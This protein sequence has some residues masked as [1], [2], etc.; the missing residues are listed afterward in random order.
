MSL[1]WLPSEDVCRRTLAMQDERGYHVAVLWRAESFRQSDGAPMTM[2]R[3]EALNAVLERC[4]LP[5]IPGELLIGSGLGR[6]AH[7]GDA[8]Q[9]AEAQQ[10][11]GGI[12]SRDFWTHFDHYI[13]DYPTLLR[14]GLDGIIA[15][16]EAQMAAQDEQGKVFLAS[17]V[18]GLRGASRHI[19]RWA[20]AAE[21]QAAQSPEYAELLRAQA[22]MARRIAHQPPQGFWEALQLVHFM[23]SIFQLDERYAMALGRLDQYL[24]PFYQADCAAQRLTPELAENLMHHLIA[25]LAHRGDIQNICIGGVDAQ[26]NDATNELSFLILES[27]KRIGQPGGNLTARIHKQSPEPFLRKCAEVIRTGIGFPA[28][29]NDEVQIAGLVGQG[30]PLEDARDYAFVGCI[31]AFIP[32]KQAPWA[33]SRFN[34]LRCINLVLWDGWDTVTQAQVGPHTGETADWEAFYEA[35]RAQMEA[36]VA[37]HVRELNAIKQP[38]EDRAEELTSPLMSALTDACLERGRDLCDGGA[39]YPGNHGICGMGIGSVADTLLVI[40]RYVFEQGRFTLDALRTMLT[41]NFEGFEGERQLLLRAPKYGN[42]EQEVDELAVRAARDFGEACLRHTTPRGGRYWGLMAANTANIY[43][44]AEVGATADGRLALQPL[45]DAAS[46]TFGRDHNGPTAVAL[47]VA[48]LDYRLFPGGNVINMKFHPSALAGEAGLAGLSALVRTCFSM[49]GIQLQFNT[50][51]REVLRKAMEHPEEYANLVVR[52][53]GFSAY[54]TWL[55]RDV[56]ED[57]LARTEHRL[58]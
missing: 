22:A 58:V 28:L 12:G 2:R 17:V 7:A 47:S 33:D 44:G 57:I 11:L 13:P 41:A 19:E 9:L 54:F 46:P 53:S 14:A 21:E 15:R 4:D 32:G 27:V 39:R 26:G 23:H 37:E 56:Q 49:G 34:M 36:G 16:A 25:K 43:A 18:C 45:S 3:A 48:K 42:D 24:Y 35:Y 30:Y 5:M 31:E 52:V 50:T 29:F 40:K 55:G 1:N 20:D 8:A 38:A 10:Y 6:L 51:D